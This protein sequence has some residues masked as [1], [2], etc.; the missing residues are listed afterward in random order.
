MS[1]TAASAIVTV[2]ALA[3]MVFA[4]GGG[5]LIQRFGERRTYLAGL[6]IVA[7]STGDV[8]FAD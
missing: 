3:R 2:F 7:L 1:L 6:L 8:A 4:P 5:W